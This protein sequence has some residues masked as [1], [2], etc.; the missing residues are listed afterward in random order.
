MIGRNEGLYHLNITALNKLSNYNLTSN[1]EEE[2]NE[3]YRNNENNDNNENNEILITNYQN[4]SNGNNRNNKQLVD[5]IIKYKLPSE[6]EENSKVVHKIYLENV[7]LLIK[8]QT[9][10]EEIKSR[11]YNELKIKSLE[12]NYSIDKISL[13]IPGEFLD[14]NKKLID[15][16][17]K[18]NDFN[19]QAFITYNSTSTNN[20]K[21]S[22]IKKK[23]LKKSHR[24]AK[25]NREILINENELVPSYLLPILTKEGY[26]C[27]PSI[28]DLSRKTAPEL[29]NVENF[30]VFNKYGEVEFKESVNLLGLNLD[31]QVTIESNLIDTGDKL[32]YW[33]I[34]K[35]YN[36]RC[37]ENGL[38]KH[39]INLEKCGGKFL[40]YKNNELVWEYRGKNSIKN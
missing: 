23:V 32:N 31:N 33:S 7:N 15:Y 2:K 9:L 21:D 16:N 30:K 18:D 1:D 34:F 14:D 11:I 19:I 3:N 20:K 25:I 35:L 24:E 39:K 28:M 8:I 6:E 38:N 22:E 37:Q 13:L 29:R 12:G 36:F 26:K 5:L 10:R 17:F 27:T 40:S 4:E